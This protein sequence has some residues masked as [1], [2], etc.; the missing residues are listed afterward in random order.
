MCGRFFLMTSKE[1]LSE[2]FAVEVPT[3]AA[4][5]NI[6]PTQPIPVVREKAN[7]QSREV[8]LVRWGLIPSWAKDLSIG[9]H[10]INARSETIAE[11][12]AF[13]NAFRRR[14]CLI[15][16]DGFYEW[17]KVGK[18]KQPHVIRA[19]NGH[20]L[21]FAGLW[22]CWEGPNGEIIESGTIIT[23]PAND[24]LKPL[25]ERMP[26]IMPPEQYAEWL[27][28]RCDTPADLLPLLKTYPDEKLKVYRVSNWVSNARH[29][30]ERCLAPDVGLFA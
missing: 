3:I 24:L 23:T 17:L 20:P 4:R 27:D 7:G 13:R 14:R 6:A 8:A 16:A 21:G 9:M 5:Y 2:H 15:P 29:E 1:T 19:V 10:T 11:K 28:P 12:P 18:E 26:V 22:E 30:G 25:H